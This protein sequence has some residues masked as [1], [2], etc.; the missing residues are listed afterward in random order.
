MLIKYSIVFLLSVIHLFAIVDINN[1]TSSEL[2]ELDG[3]GKAKA[4]KISLP[5]NGSIEEALLKLK[6]PTSEDKVSIIV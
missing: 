6:N 4:L 3:I 5:E 1:A 2:L